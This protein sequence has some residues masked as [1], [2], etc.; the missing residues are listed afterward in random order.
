MRRLLTLSL[1]AAAAVTVPAT[2]Q[3]PQP[4]ERERTF[5]YSF[6]P[7]EGEIAMSRRG[8]LGVTVDMRPDAARDTVGALIAGV[9]PG[10][11]AERAGIRAGDIVTRF[12]GTRLAGAAAANEHDS[13]EESGP[14]FRLIRFASRLEPGD[15][16]R[17]E[18]RRDGR[19]QTFTF[20][21]EESD[22]D[23]VV[24]RMAPLMREGLE[25]IPLPDQ[26]RHRVMVSMGAGVLDDLELVKNN[27]GLGRR[28]GTSEGV[29][30]VSIGA[31]SAA[32]NV[33]SGDV[34]LAIGGRRPTSPAHA[35]RI[36]STYEPGEALQFE[37]YRDGRRS[38]V[39]GAMPQR[40]EGEWRIRRNSFEVPMPDLH[41]FFEEGMRQRQRIEE[42]MPHL[43]R[44]RGTQRVIIK[45]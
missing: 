3:Q 22:M 10:G 43:E 33:R 32:L 42:L 26:V 18:V 38:T 8:R 1:I 36:L 7:G 20:Q 16:V 19:P 44:P 31:D 24:R 12:N 28:L 21:A 27:A 29:V 35:M 25:A 11:A 30:V 39:S 15:T 23:I 9:T 13:G 4:R 37:I 40:R 2:A 17:L 6:G 14:A 41:R 45:T 34:I 5:T